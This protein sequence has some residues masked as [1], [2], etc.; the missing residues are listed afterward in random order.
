MKL[1]GRRPYQEPLLL[2]GKKQMV[3]GSSPSPNIIFPLAI[4]IIRPRFLINVSNISTNVT[5]LG[6]FH[7][8]SPICI[9]PTSCHK[10][11]HPDGELATAGAAADA[12]T[13]YVVSTAATTKLEDVSNGAGDGPRWFQLYVQK[14]RGRTLELIRRAEKAGYGALVVTV[15]HPVMANRRADLRNDFRLPEPLR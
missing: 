10:L 1:P 12:A 14:D 5:L 8:R 13:L 4:L 6:K 7:L 3:K 11:A 2:K 9:A 15:D